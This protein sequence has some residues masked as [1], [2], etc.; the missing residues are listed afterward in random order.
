MRVL[1]VSPYAITYFILFVPVGLLV[2]LW[3]GFAFSYWPY[4]NVF[5]LLKKGWLVSG[6]TL[7]LA[8]NSWAQ[9]YHPEPLS[10]IAGTMLECQL[11][12]GF[13]CFIRFLI[14]CICEPFLSYIHSTCIYLVSYQSLYS[15]V[16][17]LIYGTK[18]LTIN[19]F[20]ILLITYPNIL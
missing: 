14:H 2:V 11:T 20:G 17:F 6:E 13:K 16:L 12:L 7:L 3:L 4:F 18:H 19:V 5:W 15:Y 8:L 1:I 10:R 9:S